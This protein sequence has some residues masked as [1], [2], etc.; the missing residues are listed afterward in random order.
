L[1]LIARNDE[2]FVLSRESEDCSDH[3]RGAHYRRA[4]QIETQAA[5]Q[6]GQTVNLH[7]AT[8][9]ADASRFDLADY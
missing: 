1:E 3:A 2:A 6:L 5:C 7:L 8:C 4:T 9:G